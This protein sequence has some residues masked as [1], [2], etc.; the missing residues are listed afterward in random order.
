MTKNKAIQFADATRI[1]K[2]PEAFSVM[3]KPIG[4]K[5][6]LDCT[7][8]Y[9]LEK[10][11]LYPETSSF[12]MSE[13]TLALFIK[14]YIQEQEADTITF[15]WQGGEATLLGVDYFK[16]AVAFQKKYA[17]NKTIENSFQTNG[18]LLTNEW[19]AFFVDN[20]FLVGISI[21]GPEDLHDHYR[22][23]ANGK[24]SFKEVMKGIELL[25]KH[26]CE[27]NTLTVV[28]D[29]NA[30]YPLEI[31]RF[32]KEI[33]STFMQFIPVVE[34]RVLDKN[35]SL[36]LVNAGYKGEAEVTDWSVKPK[37]YGSFL[38]T[39]FDE[40][41]RNDV[42]RYY[43][44]LFDV[45]LGNWYGAP[46]GLCVFTETCGNAIVMEH[47]GDVYSC[48]HFVYDE[49]YIG[50]IAEQPLG[51]MLKSSKQF[52]FGI[53]KRD[54]LPIYCKRCE[55]RF[56]CHGE[57]PKHRFMEAPNGEKG[58]N[59]LCE[60]YKMFFSHVKPSMDFMM[61][62]LNNN[63]PPSNIMNHLRMLEQ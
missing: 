19:C 12:K 46:P 11:G 57:C 14:Q 27:F 10:K 54:T 47:N 18:T 63:R 23:Y 1:T 45:T 38:N 49:Y 16:K 30:K 40:W 28:N 60:S 29:Y 6:N 20:N 32:L 26:Q 35:N 34:R 50:N 22:K 51:D 33:G 9:Y 2:V 42:G 44:Q 36:K 3:S 58:L 59:Y 52:Q 43:V 39:I 13:E 21:D 41:A 25:K 56:A 62:E 61:N 4:P 48:D 24:P 15:T 53:D 5:C 37:D 31:Y 17:G 7:Y 8:C 55:F